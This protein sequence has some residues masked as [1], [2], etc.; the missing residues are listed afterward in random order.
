MVV[1]WEPG[2]DYNYGDIVE[3]EGNRYKIIQ[4]HRSQGDWTPPMTPAL[5]GAIPREE[6]DNEGQQAAYQQPQSQPG[7]SGDKGS[8]YHNSDVPAPPNYADHPDQTVQIPH[9]ESQKKWWDLDDK[10]KHELE[11]GG[12]LLAGIAAIGAGYY[13]YHEHNKSD[14]DKKALTWSFQSWLKDAERR[15]NVFR[16][17]GPQGPTTW[18]LTQGHTIPAGALIGGTDA[19]GNP[20]YIARAFIE[21]GLQ[22]GKASPTFKKGAAIGFQCEMIELPTYEILLG[23]ANAVHWVPASG[24]FSPGALRPVEG[25]QDDK[26]VPLY[27]SQAEYHGGVH[28]GKCS[29]NLGGAW[30]AFG[31]EEHEVKEYRVLCYN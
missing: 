7:Y 28:P 10:R 30:I 12:G 3:F 19:H 20:I 4:P 5:W 31:G 27:I 25:G 29:P 16:E 26:N 24:P 15:T 11:I 14:D 1:Y 22:I 21:G 17:Q 8:G 13:A 23:D 18:V 2:T 9:E 6:W